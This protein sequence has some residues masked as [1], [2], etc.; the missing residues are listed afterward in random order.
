MVAG[1]YTVR[2]LRGEELWEIEEELARLRIE[3]FEEYP[4][5]YKGT[6]A[7]E[8]DYLK[9]YL[10]SRRSVCVAVFE[11]GSF[12]LV[13]A[14]TALPLEE[15]EEEFQR[16]FEEAGEDVGGLFYF[17]ESVLRAPWRGKGLGKRF[18]EER[19]AH[20][21]S[22]LGGGLEGTTFCAVRRPDDHPLKPGGYQ[23]LSGFWR[24][25]GYERRPDLVAHYTW[26]DIGKK[27]E[28]SKEMVFWWKQH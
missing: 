13:G 6:M 12:E 22:V 7:Y 25:R 1:G 14:S 4:Y 21:L 9:M 11:E 5:L 24:S 26:Q 17:G 27:E 10:E 8:M 16:P 3:V 28:T 15:A 20:A 19:E 2:L 23:D 18:F